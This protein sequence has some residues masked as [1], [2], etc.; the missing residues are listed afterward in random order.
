MQFE[1]QISFNLFYH[2]L[3]LVTYQY[4]GVNLL[5]IISQLIKMLIVILMYTD[6][7]CFNI[8]QLIFI[9]DNTWTFSPK[10]KVQSQMGLY[11]WQRLIEDNFILHVNNLH[12]NHINTM[13]LSKDAPD[14]EVFKFVHFQS[15]IIIC[16]Y[17]YA[18]N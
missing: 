18:L 2:H 3:N 14:I 6:I 9:I 10:Y 15:N 8:N 5:E 4:I 7:I 1:F 16:Y 11:Q 12:F 17:Y 13:S